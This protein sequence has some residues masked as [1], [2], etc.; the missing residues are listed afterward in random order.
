MATCPLGADQIALLPGR[1][2]TE[3]VI[4]RL[5]RHPCRR[6]WRSHNLRC[7][8]VTSNACLTTC[9]SATAYGR[10]VPR[11]NL[12]LL[13]LARS[14]SAIL[15]LAFGGRIIGS[16]CV[17]ERALLPAPW[18]T[19]SFLLSPSTLPRDLVETLKRKARLLRWCSLVDCAFCGRCSA[20]V[21]HADQT[22][23]AVNFPWRCRAAV[24]AFNRFCRVRPAKLT[25]RY[26]RIKAPTTGAELRRAFCWSNLDQRLRYG[27]NFIALPFLRQLN[28]VTGLLRGRLVLCYCSN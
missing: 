1:K 8:L 19:R 17:A 28:E 25:R 13:L 15:M 20:G 11:K 14:R 9:A 16:R 26:Q 3:F 23:A 7:L 5:A 18:R 2:R 10:P 6:S 4:R 12:L 22:S 21:R 27:G 24:I